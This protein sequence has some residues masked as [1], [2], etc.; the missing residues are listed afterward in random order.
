MGGN[1]DVATVATMITKPAATIFV[2]DGQFKNLRFPPSVQPAVSSVLVDDAN[3]EAAL[4]AAALSPGCGCSSYNAVATALNHKAGGTARL[5]QL[6]GLPPA[7]APT[8]SSATS[9]SVGAVVTV[10]AQASTLTVDISSHDTQYAPCPAFTATS[11]TDTLLG[12]PGLHAGDYGIITV[13]PTAACIDLVSVLPPPHPPQCSTTGSNGAAVVAWEGYNPTSHAVLY[14]PTG[15]NEPVLVQRWCQTPTISN[16]SG[17]AVPPSQI[18]PGTA[19]QLLI[20]ADGWITTY[21]R[22]SRSSSLR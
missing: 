16:A 6:L 17:I 5:R 3:V 2:L 21:Q 14:Q 19:V 13:D 12:L 18:A 7:T 10:D 20:S 1:L 9:T 15:Q 4:N 11:P 22:Q 8:S